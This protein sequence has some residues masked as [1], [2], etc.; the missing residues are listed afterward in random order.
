MIIGLT[1]DLRNDYIKMGFSEEDTAEFDREDT[2]EAI[3][4]TLQELGYQTKKIGNVYHLINALGR[5]ERWDLVFNICEGLYGVSRESQVPSILDA[6]QIPYTFSNGLILSVAMHKGLCKQMIKQ[7]KI[8]TAPYVVLANMEQIKSVKIPYPLFAKPV[9]EGTS[10][11]ITP[12]SKIDNIEELKKICDYLFKNYKQPVIVEKYLPGREFTVGIVGNGKTAKAIACMEIIIKDE[13]NR[14]IYTYE[15]KEKCEEQVIY[16]LA[17]DDIAKKA[18][19]LAVKSYQGL[20]CQDTGRVDL[21]LDEK[22][23]INFIEINPIPGLHPTHSDLPM[24]ADFAGISYQQLLKMIVEAA[25]ERTLN[26]K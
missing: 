14:E 1:Y 23:I 10:K 5:D 4:L 13:K 11:G 18:M 19:S 15:A 16:K 9:A 8:P 12:H 21:K 17:Y 6:F 20:G 3:E 22:G 25:I 24:M 26:K 7:L 2:V